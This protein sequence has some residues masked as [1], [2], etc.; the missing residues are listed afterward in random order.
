MPGA[1]PPHG[2]SYPPPAAPLL[3]SGNGY[4]VSTNG[5]AIARLGLSIVG[6]L[7]LGSLLGIIFGFV[8]RSQIRRSNGTQKGAGL[9]LAGIIIGFVTFGLVLLAI[10]IPTFIGLR[11]NTPPATTLPPSPI[12]LGTP[13]QGGQ[14]LPITWEARSQPYDTTLTPTPAGV[15]M[16]IASTDQSEWAAVPVEDSFPSIQLSSSV[17][18]VAGNRSNGIG[19]GCVTPAEN[20]KF[21]FLVYQSGRWQVLM[22]LN[23]QAAIVASGTTPAIRTEGSNSLAV[24]CREDPTTPGNTQIAFEINGTRVANDLVGVSSDEWIPTIQGCSCNGPDTAG[25]T[26]L[27]YYASPDTPPTSIG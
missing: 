11:A 26:N 19:L 23:G 21:A 7:G 6:V 4:P 10:A 8:S 15:D 17:A 18:I 9:A 24:A 22:T 25:F 5:L 3:G 16:N 1:Q 2:Y 20:A 27:A 12:V 14:A 13:E